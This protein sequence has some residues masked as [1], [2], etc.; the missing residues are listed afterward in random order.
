MNTKDPTNRNLSLADVSAAADRLN[1]WGKWGTEDQIGTLNYVGEREILRAAATVRTGRVYSLALNFDTAGPQGGKT[2]FPPVGRF[3]PIHTMLR[4][5]T[6]AYAGNLDA[7]GIRSADDV[8]VLPLQ[9]C[10]HW[11]GLGHIF[12]QDHMWNGYDCREVSSF[13][14]AKCGIEHTRDRFVGRGVLLDV[15]RFLKVACLDDGFAIT[16]E[17]LEDC[18]VDQ[19]IAVERGDFLLVRTGQMSK[20]LAEGNWDY[21]AGGDAPGLSFDTLD[22]L[23]GKEVA[24]VASDTWGVEV[25]PCQTDDTV[26][27][28]WHWIC[29]PIMG[30]T[31]GE[32]FFLDELASACAEDG[33]YE[34]LFV[35]PT[36]PITGGVGGPVNPIA[37]R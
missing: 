5:G 32:I 11:D 8:V 22:W 9:A 37:I 15:A 13:G 25:R 19:R 35:A 17:I 31:M 1:N 24:A 7:R 23:Q 18:A 16:S 4:T 14:A 33:R 10:T 27:Q 29:I 26:N 12:Y 30:L 34:F 21:Y 20:K 36:L 3:N 28:P 2:K 6:D